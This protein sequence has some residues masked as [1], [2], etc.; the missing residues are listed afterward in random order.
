MKIKKEFLVLVCN[1]KNL[2]NKSIM[3][4][5]ILQL[6]NLRSMSVYTFK[7]DYIGMS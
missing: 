1:Y 2:K 5:I 4:F 3:R 7:Y 6:V